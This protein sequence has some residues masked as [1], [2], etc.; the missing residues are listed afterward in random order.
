MS[1]EQALAFALQSVGKG[2][3]TL[4]TEQ[5]SAI[6]HAYDGDDVFVWLPTGFGKSVVYECLPFLY[7][8]KLN[9]VEGPFSVALVVSP[10]LALMV[11]QVSSLRKRGVACGIMSDSEGVDKAMLVSEKELHTYHLLFCAPEALISVQRWRQLLCNP[12]LDQSIV[13]I[14]VDEA[15]CV[16]KW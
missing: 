10:L 16:S 11:D 14:A 5:V 13:A 4:K 6:R 12:P 7:D 8:Y 15:H 1:F 9:H 2:H 3:L